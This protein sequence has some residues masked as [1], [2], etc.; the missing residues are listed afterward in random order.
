MAF[1]LDG[2]WIVEPDQPQIARSAEHVILIRYRLPFIF[3]SL[4]A[5]NTDAFV[6]TTPWRT[7]RHVR[8][9]RRCRTILSTR[10]HGRWR[11][12]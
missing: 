10:R 11:F 9:V 1:G 12:Q 3:D 5:P 8:L 2:V 7:R 6:A 4:F